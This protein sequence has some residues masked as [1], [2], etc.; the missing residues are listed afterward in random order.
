MVKARFA[1]LTAGLLARKGEAHPAANSFAAIPGFSA[2]VFDGPQKGLVRELAGAAKPA[3]PTL[4]E[5]LDWMTTIGPAP[6]TVRSDPVPAPRRPET[7][8]VAKPILSPRL[9]TVAPS[10]TP[11]GNGQIKGAAALLRRVG[12]AP[13]PVAVPTAP[14]AAPVGRR[15]H[16]TVRLDEA[17]YVRLKIGALRMH[18]TGQDILTRALDAY[19]TALGIEPVTEADLETLRAS[20]DHGLR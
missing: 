11:I 12:K 20:P 15:V 17:R 16:V 8:M 1:S 7:V 2:P 4:Q 14:P 10:A 19:L 9:V 13:T 6:V 18:R 3:E 5:E